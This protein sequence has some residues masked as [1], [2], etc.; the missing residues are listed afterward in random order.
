M[1]GRD[2]MCTELPSEKSSGYGKILNRAK[3]HTNAGGGFAFHANRTAGVGERKFRLSNR[4]SS[5]KPSTRN[6]GGEPAGEGLP[7]RQDGRRKPIYR[8]QK[9]VVRSHSSEVSGAV[10]EDQNFHGSILFVIGY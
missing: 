4:C 2:P 5:G 9:S 3:K 8:G 10:V 7:L 6:Q 1:S